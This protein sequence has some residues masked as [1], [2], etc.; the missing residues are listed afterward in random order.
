MGEKKALWLDSRDSNC[1]GISW[2]RQ[3]LKQKI[4]WKFCRILDYCK[5]FFFFSVFILQNCKWAVVHT[6]CAQVSI[7]HSLQNA[8]FNSLLDVSL[9]REHEDIDS[10]VLI[11]F[12]KSFCMEECSFDFNVNS[13]SLFCWFQISNCFH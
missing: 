1:I 10:A 2:R 12:S 3:F 9:H 8:G 13:N 7:M 6:L 4:N 5:N 11:K